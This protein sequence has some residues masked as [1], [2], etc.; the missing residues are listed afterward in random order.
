MVNI[1]T[2]YQRVLTIAN[3][4]QR[5]YITP[6]EFNLLANQAQIAVFEQYFYD[7]GQSA[8]VPGNSTEYSDIDSMLQEK[9]ALF[10]VNNILIPGGTTLPI[11]LYRLG[12]VF[13]NQ[14]GINY[15]VKYISSK[16]LPA[17]QSSPLLQPTNERPIY[18]RSGD[19]IQVFG[20]DN[21]PLTTG[22]LCNFIQQPEKVEWGYDVVGE[23]ALYNG[24]PTRT[25][26]FQHHTSDE[27]ELVMKVLELAGVIIEDPGVV[28]YANQKIN[29]SVQQEKA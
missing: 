23:R 22:V 7:R 15:E 14:L 13:Y 25:T 4:E 10:T 18:V 2:V 9:I 5:G 21:L 27:T 20:T 11:T 17:I 1:D 24:D 29:Q 26:H 12:S 28:Q 16:D 3:K 6:L 8:A 19:T